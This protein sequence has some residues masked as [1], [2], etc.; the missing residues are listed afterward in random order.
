MMTPKEMIEM[1]MGYGFPYIITSAFVEMHIRYGYATPYAGRPVSTELDE[2]MTELGH[3]PVEDVS[4]KAKHPNFGY[5][6]FTLQKYVR[7]KDRKGRPYYRMFIFNECG[8]LLDERGPFA[9]REVVSDMD[10]LMDKFMKSDEGVTTLA[11]NPVS[12]FKYITTSPA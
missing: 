12:E 3:V 5:C 4:F 2:G 6:A 7:M 10:H 9:E 8:E 11:S 1:I